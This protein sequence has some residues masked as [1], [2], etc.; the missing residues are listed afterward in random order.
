MKMLS[1]LSRPILYILFGFFLVLIGISGFLF[2]ENRDFNKKNR[3]L[4]IAND[5][6]MSVNIELH[7]ALQKKYPS[8]FKKTSV[9]S[10]KK[11]SSE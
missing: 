9:A 10:F 5:S 7:Q 4:I 11:P 3:D 1:P 8:S 2:K 6:I